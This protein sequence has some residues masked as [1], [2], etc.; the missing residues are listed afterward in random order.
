[1]GSV[2]G[3]VVITIVLGIFISIASVA[4]S[5]GMI[6]RSLAR[7]IDGCLHERV[8]DDRVQEHPDQQRNNRGTFA[9]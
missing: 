8:A 7:K 9:V 5:Q 1:M 2:L 4:W 3:G 6:G